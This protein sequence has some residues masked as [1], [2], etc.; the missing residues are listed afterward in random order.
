ME[1]QSWVPDSVD[2]SQPSMARM[3]DYALG[4]SHN[5]AADRE[6]AERVLAANP[7]NRLGMY[8][9]RL[10]LRRAVQFLVRAGVTQFLDIGSGI[11]TVGNVHEVAQGANPACKVVYVDIDPVAVIHSNQILADNDR[12]MAIQEDVREPERILGH[13]DVR[14]LVDFEAPVALLMLCILH[15]VPDEQDPAG[16]VA[17]YRDRLAPGSYLAVSHVTSDESEEQARAMNVY[18]QVM[19]QV[20]VRGRAQVMA[21]F[22]GFELVDPGLVFVSQ[23]RPEPGEDTGRALLY[24]SGV[25]RRP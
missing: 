19:R 13:P 3:Y 11:P 14:A 23:W 8:A 24:Y 16:L 1:H 25:G 4:G 10:F 9:N 2:T 18:S 15:F 21:M 20:N 17:R 7:D 6:A 22:D 12:A 5:F